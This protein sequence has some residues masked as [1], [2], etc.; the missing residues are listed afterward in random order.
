[1]KNR[2]CVEKK[3]LILLRNGITSFEGIDKI[4]VEKDEIKKV[5]E[6]IKNGS[7]PLL[8]E[9]PY[10]DGKTHI[11]HIMQ[12]TALDEGNIVAYVQFDSQ[13]PMHL[14]SKIFFQVFTNLMYVRDGKRFGIH[15]L[16]Q[17]YV[18]KVNSEGKFTKAGSQFFDHPYLHPLHRTVTEVQRK[19]SNLNDSRYF[20]LWRYIF[21]GGVN[22]DWDMKNIPP[23]NYSTTGNVYFDIFSRITL[24]ARELGFKKIILLFDEL[25]TQHNPL[26][27]AW[28][29]KSSR[30]MKALFLVSIN[31][32][33]LLTE[34]TDRYYDNE[35]GGE[36][37]LG[38]DSELIYYGSQKHVRYVPQS[39]FTDLGLRCSFSIVKNEGKTFKNFANE[40]KFE[41]VKLKKLTD[42]E[43]EE[44]LKK[45]ISLYKETLK[46]NHE[47]YEEFIS[48]FSDI[49]DEFIGKIL[50]IVKSNQDNESIR[51][52]VR[53]TVGG[54]DLFKKWR[55]T[56]IEELL[57]LN[58]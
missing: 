22:T 50:K 6:W 23:T 11:N 48:D 54:L 17:D 18:R 45:I 33:S 8:V 52:L 16:I 55:L 20:R 15:D 49:E 14:P 26:R 34:K 42:N 43:Q 41:I 2:N 36:V 35:I 1:M 4:T 5:K 28:L 19:N 3:T 7:I 32:P 29:A 13:T 24:A 46:E 47:F 21:E 10:G 53:L 58:E 30:F 9:A 44:L 56:N 27:Y 38:E 57:E 51:R 31:E 37:T 39:E 25:E 12:K 40:H